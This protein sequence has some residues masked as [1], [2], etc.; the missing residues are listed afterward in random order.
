METSTNPV[1]GED[2]SKLMGILTGFKGQYAQLHDDFTK[3]GGA[4]SETVVKLGKLTD[5]MISLQTKYADEAK[6]RLDAIEEKLNRGP[7]MPETPKSMGQRVVEDPALISAIKSGGRFAVSVALKGPIAAYLLQKDILN[8]ST[9]ISQPLAQMAVGPRLPLGVRSLVP[10]GRTSAGAVEYVEETSFTN[11]A[12]VVAEGQ[13]KPKSDKQFT[14]RSQ[15]VRTIAHYFKASKQ[16]L[17]DLPYLQTQI[18]NNGIYGVQL[19]EDNELLNGSGVAPHLQGFMTVATAAP[20]PP[21]PGVGE[22]V[23]TVVD[24]IGAAVFDLAA[25]GYMPDGTVA[26]PADWGAVA[27]V[28]NTQGN[29]I[30]AN[31]LDYT[32]G[33]RLWGTRLVLSANQAAGNFLVGAFQ[34]NSQILDREEV[35]VQVATQN[36]DDFVKNMVTVLVEERLALVIYQ[37]AA[38]EKGVTPAA[39]LAQNEGTRERTRK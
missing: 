14:V 16:T 34:G 32:S 39:V 11:N 2:I 4:Q 15:I 38:F 26:N 37:P 27:M 24:A 29:Y 1:T 13:P 22:P 30:F 17:E 20:A 7:A 18:E 5:D 23:A 8:V 21:V 9:G 31:P 35:N 28:K 33:G 25:K 36:E 10:Q 12:A 6:K 19:V 3:L